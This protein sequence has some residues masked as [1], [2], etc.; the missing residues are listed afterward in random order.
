MATLQKWA[1]QSRLPNQ[2]N[3]GPVDGCLEN[4]EHKSLV[5]VILLWSKIVDTKHQR[6]QNIDMYLNIITSE[7]TRCLWPI[8]PFSVPNYNASLK[9]GLKTKNNLSKCDW[10]SFQ[11]EFAQCGILYDGDKL[12]HVWFAHFQVGHKN[13]PCWPK[14]CCLV[15]KVTSVWVKVT[16]YS[17][18]IT[19]CSN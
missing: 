5:T 8:W 2:Q 18:N 1:L 15:L 7:R 9:T 3:N 13:L 17:N 12:P 4:A 6:C 16:S 14:E 19:F 11:Q 10:N